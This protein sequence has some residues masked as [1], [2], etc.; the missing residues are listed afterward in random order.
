MFVLQRRAGMQ[1]MT[2]NKY[3]TINLLVLPLFHTQL[4]FYL[5]SP[6]SD[7]C[8][9]SFTFQTV[10]VLVRVEVFALFTLTTVM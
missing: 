7:Q 3:I 10:V 2:V 6:S 9:P 4:Q 5:V 8:N 1:S